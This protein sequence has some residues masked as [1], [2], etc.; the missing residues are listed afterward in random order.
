LEELFFVVGKG[1]FA[2]LGV[3]AGFFLG[4]AGFFFSFVD[5]LVCGFG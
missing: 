3:L 1:F 2:S 5:F 4:V